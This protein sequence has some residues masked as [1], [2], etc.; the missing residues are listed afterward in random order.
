MSKKKRKNYYKQVYA[1]CPYCKKLSE[2]VGIFEHKQLIGYMGL[3]CKN[4][5]KQELADI[6]KIDYLF[7]PLL[8]SKIKVIK[9]L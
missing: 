2:R 7:K 9:N 5:G 6:N 1:K 8:S 3:D 4:C